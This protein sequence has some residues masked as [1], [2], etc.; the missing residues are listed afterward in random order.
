LIEGKKYEAADCNAMELTKI[1]KKQF[2]WHFLSLR[3]YHFHTMQS[4]WWQMQQREKI[5]KT[6]KSG[7]KSF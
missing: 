5:I 3:L 4:P 7:I 6:I 2:Q 1:H